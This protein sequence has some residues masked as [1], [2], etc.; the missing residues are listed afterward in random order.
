MGELKDLLIQKFSISKKEYDLICSYFAK[1]RKEAKEESFGVTFA[2]TQYCDLNC[3]HCPVNAKLVRPGQDVTFELTTE[4]VLLILDKIRDYVKKEGFK[5]FLDF[6]GGEPTLRSDIIDILKYASSKFG[7]ENIS[8]PTTGMTIDINALLEIGKYVGVIEFSLDGFER[9]HNSLRDPFKRTGINNPYLKTFNLLC[10]AL[11]SPIRDKIQVASVILKRNKNSLLILARKLRELGL[12]NYYIL[13]RAMP[14]G[15][16]VQL[17]D[18]ILDAKEYLRLF[19]EVIKIKEEDPSFKI[20]MHHSLESIYSALFTG[21]DIYLSE[22]PL[23]SGKH[24]IGIDWNGFVYFDPWELVPPF[25]MLSAGNLLD[26]D[27][28]LEDFMDD[29]ES[30]LNIAREIIKKNVRCKRCKIP[31][32]GGMRFNAMAHYISQFDPNKITKS[33][34]I[35]GFSQIDPAC[36]L[37]S[38]KKVRVFK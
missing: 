32:T 6:G 16:M 8:L 5:L 25:N 24:S 28:T 4:Q 14:V 2:I 15:R 30:I 37:L 31:C 33:H 27:K 23:G 22:L 11:N 18:E 9:E 21:E 17:K 36:L 12:R 1:R 7:A 3:A 34:L 20:C 29:P 38:L 26:K 35:A 19:I 10:E 13:R